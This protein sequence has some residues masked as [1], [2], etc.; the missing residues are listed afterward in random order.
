VVVGGRAGRNFGEPAKRVTP[1]VLVSLSTSVCRSNER[2]AVKRRCDAC[3]ELYEAKTV[4]SRFC[5]GIGCRRKRG[6]E[7]KRAE[8]RGY[9]VDHAASPPSHFFA[10]TLGTLAEAGRVETRDG[11]DAL[12]IATLLDHGWIVE[13]DGKARLD[14][15]LEAALADPEPVAEP[16]DEVSARRHA[17]LEGSS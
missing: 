12:Y 1:P 6:R 15:A 13:A 14:A 8:R 5:L 10:A 2:S 11:Q 4:R 16:V 3:G 9:V 17:R 7:A